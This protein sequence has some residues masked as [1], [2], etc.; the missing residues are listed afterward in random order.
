MA[1]ILLTFKIHEGGRLLREQTLEQSVIKIGKV[2][3]AHLQLADESV[4]RMHAIVEVTRDE[5]HLIDLGSTG[6][7][8][9]NGQKINK[10]KLVNGDT[11]QIGKSRIE[12]A[13]ATSVPAVS[14][15]PPPIP[16]PSPQPV[17]KPAAPIPMPM[18][19]STVRDE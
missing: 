3:S 10:A 4:S 16:Q 12:V 11:I 1:K 19:A 17:A 18:Q 6:G 14:V 2:P 9:V 13:I 8:F 15:V 5:V 7:T